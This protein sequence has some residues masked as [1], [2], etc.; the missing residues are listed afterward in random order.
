MGV[1]DYVRN[2]FT[3]EK[4]ATGNYIDPTSF[5]SQTGSGITV[6]QE[7]AVTFTAVW[8]A[9]RMLSES[10]AQLPITIIEKL[11]NGDKI[12]RDNHFL[13]EL[14]HRKPNQYMTQYNFIQKC[15]YDLCVAGN[16]YVKIIRNG[17]GRPT[18]LIPLDVRL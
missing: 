4:R 18:S 1:F 2:L 3:A 6:N 13:Y 10:V 11:D 14:L 17:S 8:A 7:S 15:M 5:L 16:S 9:I 12:K